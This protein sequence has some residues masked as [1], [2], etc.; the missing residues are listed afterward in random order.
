MAFVQDAAPVGSSLG[1]SAVVAALPLVCMFVMLAGFRVKAQWAALTSLS[2]A[3]LIAVVVFGMPA[4]QALSAGAEGATFALLPIMWTVVGAVWIYNMTVESGHFDV[5]RR[6]F[7]GASGDRRVQAVIIAFCFGALLE[8]LAGF[9]TPIVISAVMLV[10]LGFRPMKAAVVALVANTVAT[11]FGV[12]GTPVLTMSRVTG[13]PVA[14]IGAVVGRQVPLLALVVPLALVFLM[15]GRRGVRETWPAA[16]TVGGAFAL[17]QFVC[18]NYFVVGLGN[19]V[20]SAVSVLALVALLR[21]WRPVTTRTGGADASGADAASERRPTG[22]VS[23]LRAYAPYLVILGVFGASQVGV[24]KSLLARAGRAFDWP[25]LDVRT[26]EGLVPSAI[27]YN[28]NWLATPGTLVF[29]AGLVSIPILGLSAADALRSW[30]AA[31]TRLKW[32]IVTVM[33]VLALAYVMSLSGQTVTIG[34][35]MAAT[36]GVFALLSPFLGWLGVAATGSNT[37][38]NAL[39][40]TLQVAAAHRA[41]LDPTVLV[42]ANMSGGALGAVISPQ[43][44]ALVSSVG[45]LAGL[46]GTLFRRLLPLSLVGLAGMSVLVYLQTTDV[47]SWMLP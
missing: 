45:G 16:V 40:G 29:V 34:Q 2:V 37:S 25:G 42:A 27:T 46:E 31:L 23:T 47:L 35:A 38:S 30:L 22:P 7:A 36:G 8:A 6:S 15:D 21:V 1:L 3:L 12:L 33:S 19:I 11:P 13:L 10:G 5:L 24:V 17:A 14:E 39:F 32:P 44:L 41:G 43:N 28:L 20:A 26:A 4:G 18:T 9:G